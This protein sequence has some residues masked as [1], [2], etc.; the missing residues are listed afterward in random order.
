MWLEGRGIGASGG[1]F[2]ASAVDENDPGQNAYGL[3][4]VLDAIGCE[5][6]VLVA[7]GSAGPVAIRYVAAHPERGGDIGSC[8]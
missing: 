4:S 2:A 7:H 3:T 1:D 5:E 6:V 8:R